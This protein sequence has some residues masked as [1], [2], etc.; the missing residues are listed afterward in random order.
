MDHRAPERL[1]TLPSWLLGQASHAA[2]R[3]VADALAGHG[4]KRHHYRVLIALA[5]DGEATQA[6]L[7]RRLWLD[8]SDLHGLL[9]ELDAD[10]LTT[11]VRDE[12]DRRRNLVALTAHGKRVLARADGDVQ[13]AQSAFLAPL[14][15]AE[16]R[17]FLA[18]LTRLVDRH[19]G[20]EGSRAGRPPSR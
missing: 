12:R 4:L 14:P 17:A 5:E 6:D 20:P 10:G 1:R 9:A 11:R 2:D 18:T 16:Q 13:N 7:G 15:D 19:A 8:R 3:L